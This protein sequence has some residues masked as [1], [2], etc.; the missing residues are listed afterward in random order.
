MLCKIS[1]KHPLIIAVANLQ[2]AKNGTIRLIEEIQNHKGDGRILFVF[3]LDKNHYFHT[4]EENHYWE[5]FVAKIEDTSHIFEIKAEHVLLVEEWPT[6]SSVS[7]YEELAQVG[8]DNLQFLALEEAKDYLGKILVKTEKGGADLSLALQ[9]NILQALGDCHFFL[10]END[11]AL[12]YYEMVLELAQREG[13]AERLAEA[14]RKLAMTHTNKFDLTTAQR[15][16]HQSI[17]FAEISGIDSVLAKALF[18]LYLLSQKRTVPMDKT[19]YFQLM[20]LLVKLGFN[21]SYAYC[22]QNVDIYQVYYDS[23]NDLFRLVDIAISIYKKT[24]TDLH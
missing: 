20:D 14:Y 6:V 21:N 9:Y 18:S 10:E 4:D 12:V 16:S 15:L 1:E 2:F 5:D 19:L 7:S 11:D 24:R 3:S 17:K 23:V 22:C 8:C 13:N